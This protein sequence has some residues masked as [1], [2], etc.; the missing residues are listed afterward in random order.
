M[1]REGR[2]R[3]KLPFSAHM[4]SVRAPLLARH[5]VWSRRQSIVL[6]MQPMMCVVLLAIICCPLEVT[7][8]DS[9]LS[10]TLSANFPWRPRY[11]QVR[12]WA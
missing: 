7:T 6:G 11:L 4:S 2:R 1:R 9:S 3:G 8:V 12:V 10:K 5:G